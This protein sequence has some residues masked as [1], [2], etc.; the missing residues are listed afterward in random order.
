[1]HAYFLQQ[2]IGTIVISEHL[3]YLKLFQYGKKSPINCPKSSSLNFRP[4]IS[5]DQ[6]NTLTAEYGI[7]TVRAYLNHDS[8]CVEVINARDVIPLDPNGFSDPF[9]IIEL[10]P[11]RTFSHCAEQQTNVKKRTLNP[12]FEEYFE[13]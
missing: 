4:A 9:V 6:I 11:R 2:K 5:Q 12:V 10:L 7:L 3:N 8:L 13:L 1:M